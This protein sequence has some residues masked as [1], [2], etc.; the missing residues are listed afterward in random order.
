MRTTW[1]IICISTILIVDG[2]SLTSKGKLRKIHK[3]NIT[4]ELY[5]PSDE[6]DMFQNSEQEEEYIDNDTLTIETENGRRVFFMNATVDSTGTLHAAQEL[7][8][9]VV[10]ARFKNIPERNGMVHLAFDVSVP[11]A[12]IHPDW[13]VRLKPSA[14]VMNDTLG[15]DQVHVTGCRYR[16]RQMK[17]YELYNKFLATIITDSTELLHMDN[18][19]AFIERNIP[20]LAALRKDSALICAD[21]VS[22]LFGVSLHEAIEHFKRDILIAKNNYRKSIRGKKYAKFIKDPYINEGIRIDTVINDAN[23]DVTYCYTQGV[24]T[25][26]GLKK[27]DIYLNGGIYKNG[28]ILYDIPLSSPLTFYVSSFASLA[29]DKERFLTKVIERRASANSSAYIDYDAGEYMI[30]THLNANRHEISRIE[31]NVVELIENE[32]FYIDS[33]IIT[34]S[35]SPEGSYS[36][37]QILAKKRGDELARYFK[38]YIDRYKRKTDSLERERL[39]IIMSFEEEEYTE[40]I[41]P[42]ERFYDFDFIVKH[43]SEDWEHL[44]QLIERDSVIKDKSK[45]MEICNERNYDNREKILAAVPEYSYIK[46]NLYPELRRVRFDFHLHRRGMIKDTIHTTVPDTVY[47]AG[48]DAIARRDFKTAVQ[49]L[50]EYNDINSALA[51]IAMDYNASA[52]KILNELP[53][54]SKRDYMLA[55]AYSRTG[56]EKKAVQYYISSVEQDESMKHRGNLDPEISRLIQK[57]HIEID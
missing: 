46:E 25:R 35:C 24:P 47:R 7:E 18:L 21:S 6:N 34:A 52:L 27:I 5:M 14:L 42:K 19:E 9:I 30:D 57:Y 56:N 50:A 37:N 33:L 31:S 3:S 38:M 8:A 54:S 51:F 17:G 23:S 1:W 48:M 12:L 22:G 41:Q 26:S 16:D 13:Q 39:G 10:T 49:C 44:I 36:M 32:E 28:E 11:Q 4:A 45:I 55:I 43:N 15:F 29:E 40:L 20:E 2:C 53:E